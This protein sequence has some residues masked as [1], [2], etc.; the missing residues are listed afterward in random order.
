MLLRDRCLEGIPY[1]KTIV[2]KS[3]ELN[4]I[5]GGFINKCESISAY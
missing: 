3:K 4:N 1:T 5:V 2:L